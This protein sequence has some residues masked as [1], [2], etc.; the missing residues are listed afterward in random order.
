M[1]PELE[2]LKNAT[3]LNDLAKLLGYKPKFLA[4]IIYKIPNDDKYSEFSIPKKTGGVRKIKKPEDRLKHLQRRLANLL[5]NCFEKICNLHEKKDKLS[6]GFRKKRSIISNAQRHKGRCYV[7][8]VDLNDFFPSINFGRVRGFF[9]SNNQFQLDPKVATVIAQIACH[10][11]ELPQGSPCSPVISNLIGHLLD[12]RLSALAAK[13]NCTY[14][15]Y[16]DDLTF[17]TNRS[18]FSPLIAKRN[19]ED[20]TWTTG[21]KLR[22]E[23]RRAGF[24]INENKT[25]MQ[26]STSRQIVTGLVVNK[27]VNIKREYYRL[28]RSMCHSLFANDEFYISKNTSSVS[29]ESTCPIEASKVVENLADIETSAKVS[30]TLNQLEGMLSFIYQVKGLHDIRKSEEKRKSPAAIMTLYRKFLFYKHFF[31]LEAPLIVCEGKT[32]VIYLKCALIQLLDKFPDFVEKA[33]E[34]VSNK[35]K[36]LNMSENIKKVLAIS[37]GTGGLASLMSM[38]K[39]WMTSFEGKGKKHPV[40]ILIDNDHGADQIKKIL[41]SYNSTKPFFHFVENLYVIHTPPFNGKDDTAIEDLFTSETLETKVDGKKFNLSKQL[42]AATEYGKIVFAEKVIKPNQ[43]NI[44]F[45]GFQGVFERFVGAMTDYQN[46]QSHTK[47]S[48]N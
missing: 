24:S 21:K 7:F 12:I 2:K 27:K 43:K 47:D 5:N 35:I 15:R 45:S 20:G 26:Y 31:A 28:S 9:I 1:M 13:A 18:E 41:K 6:H 46:I 42:N 16:A 11:N 34:G 10:N 3:D 37:D 8:N 36:F 48:T 32:D 17:S 44:D 14:T 40:I 4:Y 39:Q 22:E 38:Y 33:E 19:P 23:I 30:G 29:A 25:S